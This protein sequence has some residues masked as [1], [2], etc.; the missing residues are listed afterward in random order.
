MAFD[1]K[2]FDI[3]KVLETL[4]KFDFKKVKYE[5]NIG[6]RDQQ[7]RYG[8]G[9]ATLVI[10]LF[11]GDVFLLII[12]CAL[13]ASAYVRWCPAYSGLGHNTLQEEKK[14]E[15]EKKAE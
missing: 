3:N 1:L 6:S 9:I 12:G 8:A 2:S 11:M 10:S 5:V 4:K 13:V 7:I 15:E 14:P